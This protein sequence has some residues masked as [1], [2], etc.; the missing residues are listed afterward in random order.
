VSNASHAHLSDD[1]MDRIV[2]RCDLI[3]SSSGRCQQYSVCMLNV[4]IQICSRPYCTAASL[5]ILLTNRKRKDIYVQLA[6]FLTRSGAII[7]TEYVVKYVV[8]P[9]LW[10][11][12]EH[13]GEL[14]WICA[15][16]DQEQSGDAHDEG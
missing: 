13:L 1:V 11:E 7:E 4:D 14:Q 8:A 12:L 10:N 6:L 15:V 2:H 9:A 16:I 3:F 5:G